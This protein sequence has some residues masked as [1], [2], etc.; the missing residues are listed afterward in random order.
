MTSGVRWEYHL[1]KATASRTIRNSLLTIH[2]LFTERNDDIDRDATKMLEFLS[3]SFLT[4]SLAWFKVGSDLFFT[5]HRICL[6]ENVLLQ[7]HYG[8]QNADDG[9]KGGSGEG[10]NN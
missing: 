7:K 1:S 5:M 10:N 6:D 2:H 4:A 3:L 8:H 9:N